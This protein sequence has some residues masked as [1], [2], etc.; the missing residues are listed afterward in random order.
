MEKKQMIGFKDYISEMIKTAS[1]K[2]PPRS[3]E[4]L[5]QAMR[6][7]AEAVDKERS[8]SYFDKKS[9]YRLDLVRD[10]SDEYSKVLTEA[11]LA[12]T[13]G[14]YDCI[15]YKGYFITYSD[16]PHLRSVSL[17]NGHKEY[18]YEIRFQCDALSI[19]S[20][21]E[22]HSEEEKKAL[23]DPESDLFEKTVGL[24]DEQI[25][26]LDEGKW[27][28][29]KKKLK[30]YD[31]KDYS[32]NGLR[33]NNVEWDDRNKSASD[34][35]SYLIDD[36]F[37]RREG[38]IYTED[39]FEIF[40]DVVRR[41]IFFADYG[42]RHYLVGLQGFIWYEW[43]PKTKRDKYIWRCMDE[44]G[45]GDLPDKLLENCALYYLIEDPQGWEAVADILPILALWEMCQD[46]NPDNVKNEILKVFDMIPGE[47][48]RERIEKL[49]EEDRAKAYK[50]GEHTD[51]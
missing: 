24:L 48:Y 50:E 45:Q 32:P 20:C 49:I 37:T 33:F 14:E 29:E 43:K 27:I 51:D 25:K 17:E 30:I 12:V 9:A 11:I 19:I 39:D 3:A 31:F 38:L 15:E 4:E 35:L 1:E 41:M 40:A 16:I 47:G 18:S 6:V 36:A 34:T 5:T 23:L 42:K 7:M 10:T 22:Y 2:T 28:K 44:F 26:H 46:Y 21:E 8:E 13:A